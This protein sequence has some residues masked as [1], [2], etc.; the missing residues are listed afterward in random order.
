MAA[1]ND[2][3]PDFDDFE[4]YY[5]GEM[6]SAEQRSLEGRMLAE[7]LVAE[8]YEGFLAWRA[9]HADVTGMRAEM[10][11]RLHTRTAHA[12]RNALPLWAYASAASV[13]LVLFAYWNMFLYDRNVDIQKPAVAVKQ[14]ETTSST[15]EQATLPAPVKRD[16]PLESVASS[17]IGPETSL[18]TKPVPSSQ[19]KQAPQ[20]LPKTEIALVP[21][22]LANEGAPQEAELE[23][24]DTALADSFQ[25]ETAVAQAPPQPAKALAAPGSAQAV[26]KSMAGRVKAEPSSLH[27]VSKKSEEINKQYADQELVASKPVAGDKKTYNIV[28]PADTLAPI[29]AAG[30]AAYRAYLDKN[31]GSASTTGKIVVTFVV[32]SSGTLSGLVAKGPQELQKDAIRI[33]SNGPAWAPARANGTPVTSVT[34]VQLQFRQP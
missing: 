13:L 32:S 24:I 31:T 29:P 11:E 34:E 12:R 28:V 4:R 30:W 33:I 3:I 1:T 6:S 27:T 22:V 7:P 9:Q 18:P 14:E 21:S 5:S 16:K 26:A 19:P 25:A 10:H 23:A 8:A 2:L 17:Q 20:N 15:P